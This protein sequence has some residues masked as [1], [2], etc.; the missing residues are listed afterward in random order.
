MGDHQGR[1]MFA[2]FAD[3]LGA[4]PPSPPPA[5]LPLDPA[6]GL[7]SPRPLMGPPIHKIL[8]TPLITTQ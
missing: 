2:K 5:A 4:K 7:P 8:D 1:L 6:G 3:L